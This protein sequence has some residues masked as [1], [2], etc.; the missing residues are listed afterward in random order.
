[1]KCLNRKWRD[2]SGSI[3][4][5]QIVVGLMIVAIASVGT[6]QALSYGNDKMNQQMRYRKA[7]SIAR[8]YVEYW[9]GRIHTD[10]DPT[11][12]RARQGNLNQQVD[13][14]EL[15]LGDPTTDADDVVCYVRYGSLDPIDLIETGIG[16]DYWIINV[17]VTWWE[18]D[19]PR[20]TEPQSVVFRGTMVPAGL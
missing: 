12:V 17:K 16:I 1:M 18:P 7:M 2:D 13:P 3:D 11:D 14:T 5:I 19:Q 8:S 10:F 15:D 9:Q 20:Y 4:F 6:F